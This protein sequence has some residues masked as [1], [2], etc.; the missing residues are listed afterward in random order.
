MPWNS[1][2]LHYIYN[3]PEDRLVWDVGHQGYPHK[4]LTGRREQMHT[5]R[6][7]EG[8]SPFPKRSE[9]PYDTFGVGHAGTSIGAAQGMAEGIK[10]TGSNRK[11]VAIIGDG[12]MSSGMAFEA[13]NHAGV[14]VTDMLVILNDNEMSISPNVGALSSYLTKVLSGRM[15]STVREGSKRYLAACRRCGSW[16]VVRKNT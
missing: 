3:T 12:A 8:V 11:V 9:S 4:V 6:Q 10:R 2:L 13:L 7:W 15:Y 1:P 16:R 14:C 5:V